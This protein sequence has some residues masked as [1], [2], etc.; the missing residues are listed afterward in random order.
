M[1]FLCKI[2]T[3]EIDVNNIFVFSSK[4]A[5]SMTMRYAAVIKIDYFRT[6]KTPFSIL[7]FTQ[8]WKSAI[9]LLVLSA[10]TLV[11]FGLVHYSVDAFTAM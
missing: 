6:I 9:A 2:N 4:I 11:N 1:N 8:Y 3:C 5:N 10:L 7:L